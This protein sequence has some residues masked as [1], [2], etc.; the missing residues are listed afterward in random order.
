MQMPQSRQS[1]DF[2]QCSVHVEVDIAATIM[3]E[4]CSSLS[5]N[6]RAV[7]VIVVIVSHV[8]AALRVA[9]TQITV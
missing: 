7:Y 6:V 8:S 9:K 2:S 4:R 3:M 5:Q 1:A